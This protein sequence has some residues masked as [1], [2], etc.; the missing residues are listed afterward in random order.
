MKY[1]WIWCLYFALVLDVL[2]GF[3]AYQGHW[4]GTAVMAI[5]QPVFIS[6]IYYAWK[7]RDM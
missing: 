1:M 7:H 4:E 6:Y 3:G 2:V 5:F